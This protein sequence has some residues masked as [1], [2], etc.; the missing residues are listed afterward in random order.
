MGRNVGASA[1]DEMFPVLHAPQLLARASS[2][3]QNGPQFPV[4]LE[5]SKQPQPSLCLVSAC[6]YILYVCAFVCVFAWHFQCCPRSKT[7]LMTVHREEPFSQTPGPMLIQERL[8]FVCLCVWVSK[9]D[10]DI[11]V[12]IAFIDADGGIFINA[13]KCEFTHAYT[14]VTHTFF[15]AS[16]ELVFGIHTGK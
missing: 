10:N 13:Y 14:S 7:W 9:L 4:E 12:N 2:W 11:H 5:P 3:I 8:V 6:G 1:N 15:H 16:I